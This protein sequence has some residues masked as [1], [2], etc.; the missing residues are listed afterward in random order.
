MSLAQ[1]TDTPCCKV[2]RQCLVTQL[3]TA[4]CSATLSQVTDTHS[5]KA[6]CQHAVISHQLQA[7]SATLPLSLGNRCLAA[8]FKLNRAEVLQSPQVAH[9]QCFSNMHQMCSHI[10]AVLAL[11]LQI[12]SGAT[13]C[14]LALVR[15]LQSAV[16]PYTAG[17]CTS[18]FDII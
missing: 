2:V 16:V 12:S 17:M 15:V 10:V 14:L 4:T 11:R 9:Q 3:S 13:S 5:C 1:V 6:V 8:G 18:T 7:C